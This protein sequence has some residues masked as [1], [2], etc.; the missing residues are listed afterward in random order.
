[1]FFV[2]YLIFFK[3]TVKIVIGTSNW[4]MTQCAAWWISCVGFAV[5]YTMSA[6]LRV[7]V[8]FMSIIF[9]IP[10]F[11][12]WL[13]FPSCSFA[14]ANC[15]CYQFVSFCLGLHVVYGT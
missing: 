8:L 12:F 14:V 7:I 15:A 13:F 10:G 1:M 5:P 11:M 2:L 4:G 9:A 6:Q 3:F